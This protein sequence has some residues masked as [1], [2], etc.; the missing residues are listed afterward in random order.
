MTESSVPWRE[1]WEE[2]GLALGRLLQEFDGLRHRH[3]LLH[4]VAN[5]DALA[6]TEV[7][8][9][10]QTVGDADHRPIIELD[11]LP[12]HVDDPA[13]DLAFPLID[14]G[15]GR[16][17][18]CGE[19]R[20]KREQNR[21]QD[22]PPTY[23]APAWCLPARPSDSSRHGSSLLQGDEANDMPRHRGPSSALS[24]RAWALQPRDET[25]GL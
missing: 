15:L 20:H 2:L 11:H 14:G 4:L 13:L 5:L 24:P 21:G 25:T 23:P 8:L 7:A 22:S 12:V 17:G 19:R 1:R 6:F 9:E 10:G 3:A 18:T 16:N